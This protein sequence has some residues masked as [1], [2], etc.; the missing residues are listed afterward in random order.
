MYAEHF[1]L[2]TKPFS[3]TAGG[4]AVFV[5]PQ[6][7]EVMKSLNK[8]LR[9]IDSVVAVSGPVG[10]GKT[11]IVTRALE[12][13]SPGRMVAWIGR[14]GLASDEVL[15]LL[16]AGFGVNY[17][18]MSTIHR[19]AAFRRLLAE[20]TAAGTRFAIVVEDAQRL[21]SEALAELEALTAADSGD[22]LGANLIL[23]GQPGLNDWLATPDLARVNQRTR[24]RQS[25]EP[26]GAAEVKGYLRNCVRVAGGDYDSLFARGTANMLYRCSEGIPRIINNLC[27]SGL[28]TVAENGAG[29]VT[30]D[31]IRKIAKEALGVDVQIEAEEEA[32]HVAAAEPQP[33]ATPTDASEPPSST[34]PDENAVGTTDAQPAPIVEPTASEP[35]PSRLPEESVVEAMDAP[36]APAPDT[37]HLQPAP[38]M[39]PEESAEES[40]VGTTDAL[41]STMTQKRQ[42]WMLQSPDDDKNENDEEIPLE[43]TV[44]VEATARLPRIDADATVNPDHANEEPGAQFTIASTITIEHPTLAEIDLAT[45]AATPAANPAAAAQPDPAPELE[46]AAA[47][48]PDTEPAAEAEPETAPDLELEPLPEPE[49]A[50]DS[51]PDPTL[52]LELVSESAAEAPGRIDAEEISAVDA[53]S[54][55]AQDGLDPTLEGIPTLT[56]DDSLDK[57]RNNV[58]KPELTAEKPGGDVDTKMAEDLS[59]AKSLDDLDDEMAATLFGDEAFD[60]IAAAAIA[61][62]PANVA[63]AAAPSDDSD[64]IVADETTVGGAEPAAEP[65][66]QLEPKA[67]AEPAAKAVAEPAPKA[68]DTSPKQAPV[69]AP[70]PPKS[71]EEQM[72][73]ANGASP[74][75]PGGGKTAKSGSNKKSKPKKR[76]GLLSRFKR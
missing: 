6:Q 63:E 76:G 19:F 16:L 46:A 31:V 40:E 21:E 45:M 10:V 57:A 30:A 44:E 27:E 15:E 67:A 75:A 72:N 23:M 3:S 32:E 69:Q 24:L 14:M 22:A 41:E 5:G 56:L 28:T 62:A 64:T 1:G 68:A 36:P 65:E 8:G 74:G 29:T 60:A 35:A 43:L 50:A 52:E 51:Q 55:E 59:K 73:S 20:R 7:A 61:N 42:G 34:L 39:Q 13:L 26:L 25:V 49:T 2:K 37:T 33:V 47:P 54:E 48:E 11:T 4:S 12:S 17:K 66:I 18:S 70:P 58:T 38:S 9:A 71:L 53:A